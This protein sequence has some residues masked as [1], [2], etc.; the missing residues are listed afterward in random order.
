MKVM[1][2]Y[3]FITENLKVTENLNERRERGREKSEVQL[4]L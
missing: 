1:R 2:L 3:V 4:S